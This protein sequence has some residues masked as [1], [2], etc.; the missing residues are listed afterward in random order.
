MFYKSLVHKLC[1]MFFTNM[2]YE[3]MNIYF[4]SVLTPSSFY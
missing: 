3:I 1:R 4:E 2:C